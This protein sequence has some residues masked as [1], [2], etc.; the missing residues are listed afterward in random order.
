MAGMRAMV[1]AAGVGE[2]MR[3]LTDHLPKPLLPIANRPVM[4]YVLEHLGRHGFTEVIANLHY[5]P[6]EIV[7]HFGDGSEY[8]VQLTFSYERELLG[9]AGGVGQC[10]SFLGGDTFLVTGADDLTRMD[11]TELV[12]AHRR[13]GAIASIGL[14]EVEDTSEYGIVVTDDEG[15]I[16]R[17]VEKPKGEAPSRT[18]N[19]QI[20]LFEP[21][22]FNF[23]PPDRFYDWGFHAFPAMVEA[24]VPFYGFQLDG[25]W[26]DIGSIEDYIAANVDVLERRFEARMVGTEVEPGVW[27]GEGATIEP[28]G[29]VVPPV[30]IGDGCVVRPGASVGAGTSVGGGVEIPSGSSLSACVVWARARIPRGVRLDRAVVTA[31]GVFRG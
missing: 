1:L 10:K 31:G 27:L 25:Y 29:K 28:S 19:T 8:G 18:A 4:G 2:R 5:R 23:V 3:P 9:P 14:V 15:R 17:F 30:V 21:D 24:G 13:V 22:V 26:R 7:E 12:S 20:Y 6:Q 11:L 16:Q